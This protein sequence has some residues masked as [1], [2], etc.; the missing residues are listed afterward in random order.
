[1]ET[2]RQRGHQPWKVWEKDQIEE[3]QTPWKELP[4][5]RLDRGRAQA[6]E[7]PGKRSDALKESLLFSKN[8]RKYMEA[9]QG[10]QGSRYLIAAPSLPLRECTV[11]CHCLLTL[12]TLSSQLSGHNIQWHRGFQTFRD[13]NGLPECITFENRGTSLLQLILLPSTPLLPLFTFSESLLRSRYTRGGADG[14]GG[15]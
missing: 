5:K 11:T 8:P 2:I 9:Q 14:G 13:S 10:P 3:G 4:G 12:P 1:M 7:K 6:L 15:R